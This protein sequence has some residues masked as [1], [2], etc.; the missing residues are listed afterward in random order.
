MFQ[1]TL[2]ARLLLSLHKDEIIKRIFALLAWK[3]LE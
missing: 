3:A 2:G 1:C